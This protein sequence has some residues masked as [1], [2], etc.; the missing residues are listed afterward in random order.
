MIMVV[1]KYHYSRL[2]ER[3]ELY[4]EF[5]NVHSDKVLL[6]MSTDQAYEVPPCEDIMGYTPGNFPV[7][8]YYPTADIKPTWMYEAGKMVNG[9]FDPEMVWYSENGSLFD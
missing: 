5:P 3:Y 4:R 2:N 6:K 7:Q 8:L 9:K 1:K